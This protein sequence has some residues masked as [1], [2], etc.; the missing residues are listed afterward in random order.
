[1]DPLIEQLKLLI[2]EAV[3]LEDVTPEQIDPAD[4]IFESGLGL[5]SIDALEIVVEVEARYGIQIPDIEVG[6][7]ALASVN[8]LAQYIRENSET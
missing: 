4:S 1:M 5:D 2:I 6:R 3:N 8:A 7:Q